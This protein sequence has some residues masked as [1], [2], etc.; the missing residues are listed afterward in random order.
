MTGREA[1]RGRALGVLLAA[2]VLSSC[3]STAFEPSELGRAQRATDA[4]PATVLETA[5]VDAAST[6]FVASWGS[7]R[8]FV[9]RSS[10]EDLGTCLVVVAEDPQTSASSCSR[11]GGVLEMSVAGDRYLLGESAD[12]GRSEQWTELTE[13]VYA[14]S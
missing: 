7:S 5:Q 14:L 13:G 11:P 4:V 3:T 8:V 2:A 10:Q 1:L 9:A 12:A 6:R